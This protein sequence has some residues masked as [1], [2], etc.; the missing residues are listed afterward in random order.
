MANDFRNCAVVTAWVCCRWKPSA[1]SLDSNL[2]LLPALSRCDR[3][4]TDVSASVLAAAAPHGREAAKY[5]AHHSTRSGYAWLVVRRRKL[6]T[7]VLVSRRAGPCGSVDDFPKSI[8]TRAVDS[9]RVVNYHGLV[10]PLVF[11][12][13]RWLQ[14]RICSTT[15]CFG[16]S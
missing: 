4:G 15:I 1:F 10:C 8:C 13:E 5:L 7:F 9:R 11:V 12:L 6:S 16:R 14:E 2:S 3:L